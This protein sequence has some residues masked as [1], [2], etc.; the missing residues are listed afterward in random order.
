MAHPHG[1][2]GGTLVEVVVALT[3]LTIGLMG[4][5]ATAL[6]SHRMLDGGRWATRLAVLG[7]SR[8]E[9]LR[10]AAQDSAICRSSRSGARSLGPAREQWSAT[11]AGAMLRLQALLD[12]PVRGS[13]VAETLQTVVWCP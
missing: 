8:L 13:A 6:A 11:P 3:L 4:V 1:S 12:R 9:V 2:H 7:D 10:T 5:T